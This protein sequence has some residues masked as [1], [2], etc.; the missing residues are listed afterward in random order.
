MA[1]LFFLLAGLLL[2]MPEDVASQGQSL[3]ARVEALETAVAS[4]QNEVAALQAAALG[5][6]TGRWEG[7]LTIPPGPCSNVGTRSFSAVLVELPT[8]DITGSLKIPNAASSSVFGQRLGSAISFDSGGYGTLFQGTLEDVNNM[9][10]TLASPSGSACPQGT[11]SAQ[12]I[13]P[14]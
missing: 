11:W 10:G 9:S 6:V 4:L 2:V 3:S 8:G 1:G 13:P 7:M 14:Q 12:R 5:G